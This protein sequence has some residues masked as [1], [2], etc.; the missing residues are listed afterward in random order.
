[1]FS[2]LF[3]SFILFYCPPFSLI[4]GLSG[5]PPLGGYNLE[6]PNLVFSKLGGAG[7][8]SQLK[9]HGEFGILMCAGTVLPLMEVP[10]YIFLESS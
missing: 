4:R 7:E 5:P 2:I 1:M 9:A 8:E 6:V 3:Y 10:N